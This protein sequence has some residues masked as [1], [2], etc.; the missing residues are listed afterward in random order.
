MSIV[1]NG[2]GSAGWVSGDIAIDLGTANTL[3]WVRSKG[4]IINEPSIIA[5]DIN[6]GS[7]I[8][9][10]K[11]A[12]RM[13]GRTHKA[14]ET[15]RPLRDG[16]IADFEATDGMLLGFV[17]KIN[18]SPIARF[19]MV[20]CVP[21]GVTAVERKA[22]RDSAERANGR[23]VYLVEEPVAAAI[24]IGIDIS[25]PVGNMIVDIGGGTAEIAVIALNGV[26]TKETIK[27]A[28]REMDKAV[29]QWF[30]NEHKLDVGEP[31]AEKIKKQVGTA[32]RME[33]TPIHVKGRDLVSGIPKTVEVSS[34][35]I[36]QA[37]K[38][39]VTLIV[40]AIKRALEKTPPELAVDILDRGIILT[41]GGSLLKG[42]DQNIRERTNLPTNVSERPLTDVVIGTGMVLSDVRNFTDVLM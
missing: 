34:D 13:V 31:T 38:D 41:G 15:I 9:V 27:V 7:V 4:I 23:E 20:I 30:R 22:V 25:K 28:G 10:G 6:D 42:L 21:S 37:L 18:F 5:R 14:I 1:K 26:V 33:Q 16:V 2:I 29:V 40:D 12:S 11:E 3:I 32:M 17:K 8:A 36:R 39:S 19:K 35:E 24:G